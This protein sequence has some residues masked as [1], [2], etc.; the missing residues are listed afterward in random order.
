MS[1]K[2]GPVSIVTIAEELG[3]SVASVSRVV[4]N[5]TGVSEPLRRRILEKLREYDFRTNYP[6]QR[7]PRIAIVSFSP[8]LSSYHTM[9]MNGIFACLL[10]HD[11]MPCT[12]FYKSGGRESL[13]ELLRDQQCSGVILIVPS[14][15]SVELPELAD[16]GLPVMLLDEPADIPGIGYI[17]NDSYAGSLKAAQLLLSLGHRRIAYILSGY[18]T[19]NHQQRFNAYRDAVSEAGCGITV[20]TEPQ[21]D[22]SRFLKDHVEITAVM[23]T[24]DDIAIRVLRAAYGLHIRVPDDLSVIGFDDYPVSSELCP[25]L[26]TIRRPLA[27]A[28]RMAAESILNFLESNGKGLLPRRILPTELVIRDTTSPCKNK[29]GGS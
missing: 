27:E 16:S 29:K 22:I 15:F 23:T 12:L 8:S 3:I 6:A 5:R 4:N 1:R 10:E 19:I 21:Q 25:P 13:L 14:H 24:N 2:R 17:D 7:R 20:M 9:L 26:T 28:G 11:V 18:R